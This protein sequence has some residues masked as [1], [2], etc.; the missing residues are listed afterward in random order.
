M[1]KLKMSML[2]LKKTFSAVKISNQLLLKMNINPL[3]AP[4]NEASIMKHW[5]YT[6][7]VYISC[8]CITFN[9][10]SYIRDAINGMLAQV[11]DYRFEVIIHDDV[12]TDNTRKIIKRYQEKYP[13]IIKLILQK[14]NQ[15][16]KGKKIIPLAVVEAK[17]EYIALC[18]GDDYWIRDD[19]IHKQF[20]LL[21]NNKNVNI[22]FSSCKSISSDHVV[23][24]VSHYGNNEIL[25]TTEQVVEGGGAFMPTASLML[26]SNTIKNLP[27]W[28]YNVPVGDYFMQI[29]A[30]VSNGSLYLP[31][32]TC[33]YRTNAI[34]SWSSSRKN[35]TKYEINSEAILYEKSLSKLS[36]YGISKN[37]INNVIAKQYIM[38]TKLAIKNNFFIDSKRLIIKSW[39]FS[40]RMSKN[41]M[42]LYYTRMIHPLIKM[43]YL[44]KTNIFKYIPKI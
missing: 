29:I 43:M 31:E 17:G 24:V 27:E 21:S 44:F 5:K 38:L 16:S 13:N 32:I 33:V 42:F 8:V 25:F 18:E 19:K 12:S 6:D 40:P 10:E 37:T 4:E 30:S 41:Q 22:C 7:K 39:F 9:Q 36:E 2:P 28:F 23:K 11:T 1:V 14:E 20:N 26:H 15:Y 3:K 35:L 34:G